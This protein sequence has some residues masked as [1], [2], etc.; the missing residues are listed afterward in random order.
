VI[1]ARIVFGEIAGAGAQ[2]EFGAGARIEGVVNSTLVGSTCAAATHLIFKTGATNATSTGLFEALYCKVENQDGTPAALAGATVQALRLVTQLNEDPGEHAMIR[3][4]TEG[5]D[6]PDY[7]FTA[8]DINAIAGTVSSGD[9]PAL[10]AGDVMCKV[11][12]DT[13][14][15]AGDYYIALLADSG[16]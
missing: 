14:T 13:G 11:Q 4:E 15:G 3:F 12:I 2:G 6:K 5:S 8:K 16:S 9:A 1:L 7:L 10:A